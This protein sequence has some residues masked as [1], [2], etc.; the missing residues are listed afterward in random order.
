MDPQEQT[1]G[2]VEAYETVP[3]RLHPRVF[4]ALGQ[5]LVTDD[6]V[7][8]IELIKN[9]YDAFAENV[10]LRFL[11]DPLEGK[12]LE[13]TD[14]GSGMT[15]QTIEDVWCLVATPYKDTNPTV[16]KGGKVR[17]VVGEK[18][19][20]RLSAARLGKRLRMLTQVARC[21]CW[22]VTVDWNAISQGE[23][24]S[25]SFVAIRE[26]PEVSP[27]AASGTRLLI[28]GLSEQWDEQRI[29]DL[30]ENLSRLISPFSE[31]NDFN[32]FIRGFND[33][34]TEEIQISSPKFLSQPKYRIKG[35]ADM[36]GK[37]EAVYQFAPLARE[38]TP[39]TRIVTKSWESITGEFGDDKWVRYFGKGAGCGPFPFEIRAWDIA[40]ADT[41]EISETFGHERRSIRKAISSH[42]GISVYRDGVLVLPKS[43]KARDWLG[44]DLRR[45]SDTGRRLSTSQLVGYV[46]I[47]ADDNPK[48]S[49]TSDRER[50]ASPRRSRGV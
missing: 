5:N 12:L 19:L 41:K 11:K 14:D 29:E 44:L 43:E 8:V 25:Q 6:V 30:E 35:T 24:L 18:G 38:G 13:I 23:D 48:I 32:I 39:R 46:S 16:K 45:V 50:L 40:S 31:A 34:K 27:F 36:H 47:S 37:V 26:F 4:A 7:A 20:G 15:R 21:P 2:H 33:G 22:E 17:R 3:F 42:K 1:N 49:D 28:S 10:W 9:S